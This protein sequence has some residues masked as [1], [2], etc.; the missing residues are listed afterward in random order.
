MSGDAILTR[1]SEC[2]AKKLLEIGKDAKIWGIAMALF[3]HYFD[4]KSIF[5]R[6]A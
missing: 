5:F 3:I 2:E 6:N 1:E 4:A